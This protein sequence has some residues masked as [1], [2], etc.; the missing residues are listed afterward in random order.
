[1]SASP[2]RTVLAPLYHDATGAT[3][4][5]YGLIAALIA[6]AAMAALGG[7]GGGLSTTYGS[8]G[9]SLMDSSRRA[10]ECLPA[11]PPVANPARVA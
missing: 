8:V 5:E 10:A 11:T 4:L 2:A 3:A 9:C 1:M 7:L 6:V